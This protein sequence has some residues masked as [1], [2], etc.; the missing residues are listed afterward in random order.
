MKL[1]L[2]KIGYG[3]LCNEFK[4]LLLYIF[5][6]NM[7]LDKIKIPELEIDLDKNDIV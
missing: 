7:T 4:I 5:N 6:V 2:Y 1:N 3:K